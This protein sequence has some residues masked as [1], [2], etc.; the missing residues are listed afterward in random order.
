[1]QEA[2][3]HLNLYGGQGN[4]TTIPNLSGAKL[5]AF[6][7]PKPPI[8]EQR[9]IAYVLSRIQ[10][11]IEVQDRIIAAT[12]ELKKALMQKLFTEGLHEE[13]LKDTEIGKMPKSWDVKKVDE[14]YEFMQ[15]GISNEPPR[16]KLRGI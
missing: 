6:Q 8:Q 1:M 5:K 15:Y 4:K 2:I 12:K 7:V 11:A 16:S 3:V 13:E 14:V 9:A 10:K